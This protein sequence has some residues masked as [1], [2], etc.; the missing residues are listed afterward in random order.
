MICVLTMIKLEI[1]S[2]TFHE[3]CKKLGTGMS[4]VQYQVKN[5]IFSGLNIKRFQ[6]LRTSESLI[7][8]VIENYS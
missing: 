2:P 8:Q 6:G 7:K 1:N 5:K 3:V 4:P